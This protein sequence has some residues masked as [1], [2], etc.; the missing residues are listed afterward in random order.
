MA[1]LAIGK[2]IALATMG[3]MFGG[4]TGKLLDIQDIGICYPIKIICHNTAFPPYEIS[5]P[6]FIL[7]L[8]LAL[9]D[10]VKGDLTLHAPTLPWSHS[11]HLDSLDHA[12]IR[13]GYEV[14]KQVN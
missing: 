10:S 8:A 6:L 5:L 7:A 9:D 13:R 12:S 4:G 11:G 14:Y 3:T 2:K 1:G